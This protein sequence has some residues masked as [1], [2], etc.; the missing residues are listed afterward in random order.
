NRLAR[1]WQRPDTIIV[2]EQAWTATAKMA[3]IVLPATT[4]YEREDIGYST[5]EALM[6]AMKPVATPPPEARDDYWIFT[7]LARRL[8]D[9]QASPDG[10]DAGKWFARMSE[11]SIPRA[12]AAGI[13]LPVFEAFREAGALRLPAPSVPVIML[14]EFRAD[15]H[16]APLRTPSG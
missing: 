6:V 10:L 3:D 15:P 8:G 5:R 14:G 2:N 11:Q 9:D 4:A 1:A 13:E 7:E 16:A 12:A